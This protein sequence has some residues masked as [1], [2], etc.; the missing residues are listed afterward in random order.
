MSQGKISHRIVETSQDP[1][2]LGRWTSILITGKRGTKTR[3]ISAYRPTIGTS[4]G[5]VNM[6][7]HLH[8]YQSQGDTTSPR[9]KFIDDLTD[10][11]NKWKDQGE[12]IVLGGDMNT[13]DKGSSQAMQRFWAPFLEATGL[14]DVHQKHLSQSWLPPT[15]ERGSVQIDFIFSSPGLRIYRAGFLPFGKYRQL[16]HVPSRRYGCLVRST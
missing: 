10:Q 13:G 3:F 14:V 4:P 7:H 11:I 15:C 5:S 1:S 6:Q 16:H 8:L 12:Q 2:G 9:K